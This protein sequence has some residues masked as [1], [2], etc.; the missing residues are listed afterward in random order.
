[1][2][3]VINVKDPQ[4]RADEPVDWEKIDNKWSLVRLVQKCTP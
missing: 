2:R 1:M 4:D 3:R